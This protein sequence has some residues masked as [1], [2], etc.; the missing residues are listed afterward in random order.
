MDVLDIDADFGQF[1]YIIAN[2]LYAWVPS[3]VQE[4][5]LS[6]C[7]KNLAG[8][9]V[10][11]VSYNT[12]PGCHSRIMARRM[13]LYH[14]RD[15]SDQAACVES[16]R[17]FLRFIAGTARD[18]GDGYKESLADLS[19]AIEG[20]DDSFIA[21]ELLDTHNQ[22]LYFHEFHQR[23]RSNGLQYLGDTTHSVALET[24]LTA[25][26]RAH[27]Q[28]MDRTSREQC[29]DFL[30]GRK[31]RD[32]LICH[33]E[34][35]L[36]EM[37]QASA[38]RDLELG[39]PAAPPE[40]RPRF[41]ES[42]TFRA[43]NGVGFVTDNPL[44]QASLLVLHEEWP[45]H[46]GLTDVFMR[47]GEAIGQRTLSKKLRQD[48]RSELLHALGVEA[49]TAQEATPRLCSRLK[50]RPRASRLAQLQ[51]GA[52]RGAVTTLLHTSLPVDALSE[53]VLVSCDGSRTVPEVAQSLATAIGAQA[54]GV[55][56]LEKASLDEL[57]E[58][59]RVVAGTLARHGL[60]LD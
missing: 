26:G 27:L 20:V 23:L 19:Q 22:P 2:G 16:A 55:P 45:R 14:T 36:A 43:P 51:A 60:F 49:V 59:V 6:I 52:K 39:C 48:A 4:K 17:D 42:M 58:V 11:F 3:T 53:F 31:F 28:G 13:L 30:V 12:Y 37:A 10:A 25:E 24:L 47:A 35:G 44:T 34:V 1:D 7:R 54:V 33:E 15:L 41:G 8:N 56:G 38:L 32:S 46:L 9:G 57:T 18:L 29:L 40:T 50:E 21:H 5:V